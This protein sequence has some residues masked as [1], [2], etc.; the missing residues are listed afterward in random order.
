MPYAL[1][2]ELVDALVSNTNDF[3]IV[4]VRPRP[5]VQKPVNQRFAGF[6]FTEDHQ[7]FVNLHVTETNLA[8]IIIWIDQPHTFRG[9][10]G[11]T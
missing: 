10:R 11:R 1:V 5:W 6:F 4:P 8:S 3:T 2:A 9:R 7:K